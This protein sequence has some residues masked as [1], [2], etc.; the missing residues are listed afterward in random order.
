MPLISL[1][2]APFPESSAP[3]FLPLRGDR[4]CTTVLG[5][6]S[7][8]SPSS[9][10]SPAPDLRRRRRR[11]RRLPPSDE[12]S[13]PAS[14]SSESSES[15]PS[16]SSD[17]AE[18]DRF[19]PRCCASSS[20]SSWLSGPPCS[21]RPRPRPRRPRRRRRPAGRSD[22]SSSSESS[23]SSESSDHRSHR[24]CRCRLPSSAAAR[25]TA[26]GSGAARSPSPASAGIR[27][28]R[29]RGPCLAGAGQPAGLAPGPRRRGPRSSGRCGSAHRVRS[30]RPTPACWSFP[31]FAPASGLSGGPGVP[32]AERALVMG[33][34]VV[35]R[36]PRILLKPPGASLRRGHAR[37]S[38]WARSTSPGLVMVSPRAARRTRSAPC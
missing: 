8:P 34:W 16:S 17:S 27:A 5:G 18:P 12:P 38:L 13:S 3:P 14:E 29:P 23:E 7:G 6:S 20:S 4:A 19:W 11:R 21:P 35:H 24:R 22:W 9:L 28:R 31:G 15:W 26:A 25:R 2:D 30:A 37:A 10:S 33:L 36:L 32:R 1:L